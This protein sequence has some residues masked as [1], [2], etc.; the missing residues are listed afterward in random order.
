VTPA[1]LSALHARAFTTP[2]PWSEAEFVSLLADPLAFLLVEGDAGFL[3]GRAVAGE[4]EL[5]T[6]AVAPEARRLGIGRRLVSRFIYQ[7]RLRGAES[8][9]LEVAEDN[10]AAKGLYLGAGFTEAGRRRG[11]YRTPDGLTVDALVLVRSL[12]GLASHAST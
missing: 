9:F 5:L 2:R 1:D 3:L 12:P 11:Y 6:V 7:A 4:A 8:A 10:A